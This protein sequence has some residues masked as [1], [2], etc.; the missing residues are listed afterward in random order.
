MHTCLVKF[1][2]VG[3]YETYKVIIKRSKPSLCGGEMIELVLKLG[4]NTDC[5]LS[6]LPGRSHLTPQQWICI[7][8]TGP[9]KH[10]C[11]DANIVLRDKWVVK[12]GQHIRVEW[13]IQ[14]DLCCYIDEVTV[15][16]FGDEWERP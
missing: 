7:P 9:R 16:G 4:S 15:D 1:V 5:C 12:R 14:H 10:G 13:L 2:P 11:L 8:E 6:Y 3:R